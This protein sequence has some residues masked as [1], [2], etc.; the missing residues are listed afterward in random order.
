MTTTVPSYPFDDER[1]MGTIAQVGPSSVRANLPLAGKS[2]GMLHH[3]HRI[4]AG[5]VG[6]FV[7]IECDELAVFGRL[8]E[9]RLPERER[10]SVEP[11]MGQQAEIH[12]VGMIQLLATVSLATYRVVTGIS[13]YP[14]LGNRVYSAHPEFV[15]W[16]VSDASRTHSSDGTVLLD[17]ATLPDVPDA[18][19]GLTPE[20]LFG[21]HS[22]ILGATGGGKSWTVAKVIEESLRYNSKMVLLDAT[23]E[24]WTLSGPEIS[25]LSIGD[26]PL[27]PE[28]A[29]L[30]CFPHSHL[31]ESDIFAI[32]RPSGQSQ[33]PKLREAI[34]SLKL[35]TILG[36]MGN[37]KGNLI[38]KKQSR[39][40]IED[41]LKKHAAKIETAY[42]SFD[43]R[44]LPQQIK[45]ECIW[46]TDR[47]DESKFG[48][49][50]NEDQ[51]C[52]SLQMRIENIIGS[53]DYAC[54]FDPPD[55]T[56][57]KEC[58]AEFMDDADKRLLRVSLQNVP[59]G[60][61]AREIVANAIGRLLLEKA[62][63][64]E[65]RDRPLVVILDEAHQFLNRTIGDD[66]MKVELDAFG[67][68]AKEG[69]KYSLTI[70]IATQRPRDIPQD[71]LSQMGTLVVH[72]L[73]NDKDR[74]V[75]E[76]AAG[77]IDRSAAAF[78][79]TLGPGEA[80]VVGVDIPVPLSIQVAKPRQRPDSTG[81]NYQVHWSVPVVVTSEGTTLNGRRIIA[82][83]FDD[84]DYT[85]PNGDDAEGATAV[86][87]IDTV[88]GEPVGEGSLVLVEEQTWEVTE[89]DADEESAI[90]RRVL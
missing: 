13:R 60:N 56:P 85:L 73:T 10:L 27:R 30:T 8:L 53:S 75:V 87:E 52:L 88:D 31:L 34:K 35:V 69:R 5:E 71:V 25:H 50:S 19:I 55:C 57:L 90:L 39:K 84:R 66:H 48:D 7:I 51:Y 81:P 2:G 14:R 44:P 54:I 58:I 1:Y 40:P 83:D 9:V 15:R 20:Q 61:H 82:K 62:R 24:F 86:L 36:S 46:P 38:K 65:F 11:D 18:S 45:E 89:I 43:I 63:D 74:E 3:G 72:R 37:D 33:G 23:G 42:A 4:A 77:E 68:I 78:L 76:K 80:V 70:C 21:R 67:L 6:E 28:D 64:G 29:V 17:I 12:P 79:P 26:G 16:L 32:F 59:F 47:Y 49:H 41:A 22:A